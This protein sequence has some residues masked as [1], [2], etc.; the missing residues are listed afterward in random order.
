MGIWTMALPGIAPVSALVAGVLI[1]DTGPRAGFAA[2]GVTLAA[3]AL[4]AAWWL[5]PAA[6]QGAQPDQ[7]RPVPGWRHD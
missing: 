2:A 6:R 4:L 5:R 1:D 3:A 7:A